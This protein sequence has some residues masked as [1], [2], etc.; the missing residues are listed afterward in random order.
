MKQ[1]AFLSKRK[2][3]P[4]CMTGA[5]SHFFFRWNELSLHNSLCHHR[6]RHLHE[7]SDI[8]TLHVV[9][10]TIWFFAIL[11]TL[12]MNGVHDT[13]KFFV[14][15][16]GRPTEVHGILTHF[17]STCC[18]SSCIHSLAWCIKHFRIDESIYGFR[19]TTQYG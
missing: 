9:D 1:A 14:H 17:K 12:S 3:L 13:M 8:G 10:I 16:L 15:F 11:H 5:L 2:L 18:H 4:C 6:L 7:A 19:R